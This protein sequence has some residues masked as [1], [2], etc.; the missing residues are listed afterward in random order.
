MKMGTRVRE[1][2]YS[3]ATCAIILGPSR[4]A[5]GCIALASLAT[6][7]LVAATPGAPGL[8]ILAATWIACAALEALHSRAFLRGRRAARALSLARGG[9][10]A[11]QDALGQWRTGS[12]REGC[13]VA[14]WLT[15]VRWR[16]DGARLD[17]TLP[18]LPDML[19]REDFRRVR[20]MLR[21]S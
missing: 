14:P 16:P 17:R 4:S 20:V 2:K 13:F 21:W 5:A 3:E 12:L 7:A 18:I 6:V 1:H 11:V 8:R 15:V 9:G 19:S 10:I